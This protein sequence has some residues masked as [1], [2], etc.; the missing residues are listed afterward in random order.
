MMTNKKL[1]IVFL[2]QLLLI[3]S[4]WLCIYNFDQPVNAQVRSQ[5]SPE[6]LIAQKARKSGTRRRLRTSFFEEERKLKFGFG[7][8]LESALDGAQNAFA[9]PAKIS[10]FNSNAIRNLLG[11]ANG[12]ITIESRDEDDANFLNTTFTG[13]GQSGNLTFTNVS[14]GSEPR[15]GTLTVNGAVNFNGQTVQFDNVRA[16]YNAGFSNKGD[17]LSGVILVTDPNNPEKS[18]FLQLPVTQI[19]GFANRDDSEPV[20]VTGTNLSIGLPT[21]R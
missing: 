17:N 16:Q 20:T 19:D 1:Q 21:D 12:T 9:D 10:G 6:Y 14:P 5:P 15:V 7:N 13:Q 4:A 3:S 2:P 11:L 8:F 18:L